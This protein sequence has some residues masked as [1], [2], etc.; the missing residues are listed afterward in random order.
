MARASSIVT[1][2]GGGAGIRSSCRSAVS[3]GGDGSVGR[4][5]STSRR[6][7]HDGAVQPG[8]ALPPSDG[9]RVDPLTGDVAYIVAGRQRRPNLPATGCPFCPGGL[10]APEPYDVLAFPN[11]WPPLPAGRAEVVLYTPDHDATFASLGPA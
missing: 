9:Y 2:T 5:S 8:Q 7:G 6:T 1:P 4:R 10:E 11:R 3:T